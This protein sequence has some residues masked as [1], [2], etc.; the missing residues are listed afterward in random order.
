MKF[1]LNPDTRMLTDALLKLQQGETISY[2]D[3]GRVVSR[4]ISGADPALQS[5]RRRAEKDDGFVIA[6]IRKEG[7]K[8]LTDVEIVALGETGAK[9]LRRAAR[10][11]AKRLANVN[12]F[13]DLPT[14]DKA[15]HNGAMALF[16]GVV[17]ATKGSTLRRLEEAANASGQLS[18]GRTF[19]LFK[20]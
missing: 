4:K 9:S 16:S 15:K 19:E 17:A 8:R 1:E 13:D 5:A 10:R 7:M 12:R 18:L 14:E 3:L 11:H 6:T 20:G 2:A